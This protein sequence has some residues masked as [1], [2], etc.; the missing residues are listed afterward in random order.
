MFHESYETNE[1]NQ[2]NLHHRR[3]CLQSL[4]AS[5]ANI[6]LNQPSISE[7]IKEQSFHHF[8]ISTLSFWPII[9]QEAFQD[10]ISARRKIEV[11]SPLLFNSICSL[12][13]L[14]LQIE[15]QKLED[16]CI[17]SNGSRRSLSIIFYVR[18]R[19]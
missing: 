7:E 16:F 8:W 3:I 10:E 1:I 13:V 6:T 2:Y 5:N 4:D 9:C 12:A 14:F 15:D 19:Y 17:D 11:E 18:A